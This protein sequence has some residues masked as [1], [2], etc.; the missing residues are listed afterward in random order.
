MEEIA[1]IGKIARAS[2]LKKVN[3]LSGMTVFQPNPKHQKA[4]KKPLLNAGEAFFVG[5]QGL[6]P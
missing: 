3:D 4:T 1:P 6:E 5:S 2:G